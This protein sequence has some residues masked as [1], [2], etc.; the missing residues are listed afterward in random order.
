M[1]SPP[2]EEAAPPLRWELPLVSM[3]DVSLTNKEGNIFDVISLG[4]KV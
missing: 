1:G 2:L 3:G 4:E